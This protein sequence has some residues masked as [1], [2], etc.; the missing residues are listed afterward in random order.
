MTK[1]SDLKLD[2][3][4]LKAVMDRHDGGKAETV[5]DVVEADRTARRLAVEVLNSSGVPHDN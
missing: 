2:P 3:L 5:D 1:F 4:V